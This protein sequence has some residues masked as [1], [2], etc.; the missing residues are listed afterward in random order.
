MV[1]RVQQSR[2]FIGWST[3]GDRTPDQTTLTDIELVKQ[4]L[5]NTIYTRRGERRMNPMEGSI[6]W[7]LVFEPL[8]DETLSLAVDDLTRIVNAE[9]RVQLVD[10][11]IDEKP[12]GFTIGLEL[13]FLPYDIVDTLKADFD[14]NTRE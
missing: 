12:Y 4:D 14:R 6:L 8:S 10:V 9:R 1:Q 5:L 13:N 11:S 7:D 3:A 2:I